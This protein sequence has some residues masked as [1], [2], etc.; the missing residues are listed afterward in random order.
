M[1][2]PGLLAFGYY[3]VMVGKSLV[4]AYLASRTRCLV[5]VWAIGLRKLI[6]VYLR[7]YPLVKGLGD[8]F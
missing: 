8:Y 6:F 2:H 1:V 4:G 7:H 5:Q 3:S